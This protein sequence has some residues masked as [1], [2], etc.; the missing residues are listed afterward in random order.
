MK[1]LLLTLLVICLVFTACKDDEAT[2][3]NEG[4]EAPSSSVAPNT[5]PKTDE[6]KPTT[7][8]TTPAVERLERGKNCS[9]PVYRR[10]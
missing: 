9:S 2:T 4:S 10:R 1:K 3:V 5:E 6:S 8:Q 7:A